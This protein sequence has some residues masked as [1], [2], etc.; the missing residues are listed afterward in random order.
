MMMAAAGEGK[1]ARVET[2][3]KEIV[4]G[5]H[6]RVRENCGK[7]FILNKDLAR[8]LIGRSELQNSILPLFW[9]ATFYIL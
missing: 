3:K 7:M 5:P 2:S 1:N 8:A 4:A 9:H 6:L